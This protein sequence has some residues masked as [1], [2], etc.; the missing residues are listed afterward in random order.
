MI[1][2]QY[3]AKPSLDATQ[4]KLKFTWATILQRL[5]Q[6]EIDG[7]LYARAVE[8]ISLLSK[9]IFE[10]SLPPQDGGYDTEP[11]TW[12]G[13][14]R[15]LIQASYDAKQV[16]LGVNIRPSINARYERN[17]LFEATTFEL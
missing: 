3:D 8:Q 5:L 15:N 7:L 4:V 13:N 9:I 11:P 14:I 17:R 16:P 12:G 1:H 10:L 6:M 2:T